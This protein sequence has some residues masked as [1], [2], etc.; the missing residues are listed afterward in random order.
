MKRYGLLLCG[1]LLQALLAG[2]V[3]ELPR[4]IYPVDPEADGARVTLKIT[5][6]S[7]PSGMPGTKSLGEDIELN[8]LRLAVFGSKGFLKEYVKAELDADNPKTITYY[9]EWDEK[10]GEWNPNSEQTAQGYTYTVSLPISDSKRIIHFIG[11][12]PSS[13]PFGEP[14]Q[15]LPSLMSGENNDTEQK[16]AFWQILKVDGIR[17]KKSANGKYYLDEDGEP[18]TAEG[19][20]NGTQ[21]YQVDTYTEG[22]FKGIQLIRNFSRIEVDAENKENKNKA[23]ETIPSSNFKVISYALYNAP[24]HGTITPFNT[25]TN[26]FV[27]E[28][29][30]KS[31]SDLEDAG[32]PATLPAGTGFTAP[33]YVKDNFVVKDNGE[34]KQ[35]AAGVGRPPIYNADGTVK[36]PEKAVYIFERP[37]PSAD[38]PPTFL[39][40]YGHFYDPQKGE[41]GHTDLSRDCF[42][43]VELYQ[44]D[45]DHG[46]SRYYP[47][48]RNFEYEVLMTKVLAP[49][50]DTPAAAAASA[51]NADVS[52]DVATTH[53]LDISDGFARLKVS[54]WIAHTFTSAVTPGSDFS[55]IL[56]AHFSLLSGSSGMSIEKVEAKRLPM[57]N[58]GDNLINEAFPAVGEPD[59]NGWRTITFTTQGPT[60]E[61][62]TQIIRIIGTYK[63]GERDVDVYRDVTITVQPLQDLKVSVTPTV[64]KGLEK[65]LTLTVSIPDGLAESMFPLAFTIEPEDMTLA[66]ANDESNLPVTYGPSIS[67]HE[68]YTSDHT[69]TNAFQFIRTLA[70]EEYEEKEP[71]YDE[72][73]SWR[74]FTCKFKTT[75]ENSATT[76]WVKNADYFKYGLDVKC[77]ATFTNTQN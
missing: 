3:Q 15:I 63:D 32:Y 8:D 17:A 75:K 4:D 27:E 51:G 43:K 56:Q 76:I 7:N 46:I 52:A 28:Y 41:T 69:K 61:S 62:R 18:I 65:E 36:F 40:V 39:V 11:N 47:I 50:Y 49:G 16:Q 45:R 35:P 31:V 42:Y 57:E 1:L 72:G 6:P 53:L 30:S 71:Y 25:R 12:G 38:V 64:P 24:L 29:Q 19:L 37:I 67:L 44:I 10:K 14:A 5:I 54:P 73:I 68:N 26:T 21:H 77:F 2:C 20:I 23:G 9:T 74:R 13:L 48:Y 70:Y 55:R 22:L 58:D 60:A 34:F 66:P 33:N 59:E